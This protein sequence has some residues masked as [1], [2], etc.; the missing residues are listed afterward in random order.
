MQKVLDALDATRE[1]TI[2][3]GDG[4]NDIDILHFA[5]TGVAMGNAQDCARKAADMITDDIR[6]DG[7]R[8][9]MEQLKLIQNLCQVIIAAYYY[10][11]KLIKA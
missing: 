5:G 10:N 9:A 8:R 6:E 4:A 7:L 2:A 1:D 3:F 11:Y